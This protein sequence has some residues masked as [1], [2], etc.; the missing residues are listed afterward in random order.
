VIKKAVGQSIY[1]PEREEHVLRN[2]A[3]KARA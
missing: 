3:Q 2:L 1:A